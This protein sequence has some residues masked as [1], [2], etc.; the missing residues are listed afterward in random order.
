MD[1]VHSMYLQY[2]NILGIVS[3]INMDQY[4]KHILYNNSCVYN[5]Y[6]YMYTSASQVNTFLHHIKIYAFVFY[7]R[8]FR[9]QHRPMK[10]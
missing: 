4:R 9:F 3:W 6:L 1:S 5:T 2:R 7:Y 10:S 8:A